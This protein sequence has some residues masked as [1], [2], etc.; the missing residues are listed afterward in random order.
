M[1]TTLLDFGSFSGGRIFGW[2]LASGEVGLP[3]MVVAWPD[4]TV[5]VYGN[6]GTGAIEMQGSCHAGAG[7][8]LAD[9]SA[10]TYFVLRDLGGTL[11]AA[12]TVAFAEAVQQHP[13]LMRPVGTTITAVSIRIVCTAARSR[14]A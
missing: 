9:A 6:F 5:Q 14:T 10:V 7:P 11:M 13:R 8:V 4:V 3:A 12:K 2:D 1:A